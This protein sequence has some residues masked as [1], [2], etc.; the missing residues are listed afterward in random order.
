[1]SDFYH[2]GE[3]LTSSFPTAELDTRR[4]TLEDR[5]DDGYQRIDQAALSGADVSEWE[6]FWLRLL[7]EYE[8]VCRELDRAA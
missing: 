6:S 7:D 5:L 1:M 3:P 8:D 4:R 2:A